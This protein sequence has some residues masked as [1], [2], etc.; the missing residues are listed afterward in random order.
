MVTL[1]LC[2]AALGLGVAALVIALQ[3]KDNFSMGAHAGGAAIGATCVNPGSCGGS[4]SGLYSGIA[5]NY[6]GP[7]GPNGCKP[8]PHTVVDMSY[9]ANDGCACD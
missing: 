5:T 6:P 1:L 3:K 8:G 7:P 9:T 2:L 4:C